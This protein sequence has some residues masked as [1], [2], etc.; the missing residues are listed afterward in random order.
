MTFYFVSEGGIKRSKAP[1]RT[2]LTTFERTALTMRM[3]NVGEGEAIVLSLG[4]EGVLFD[5]GGVV[6]KRN[7]PLGRALLAY[8][9]AEGIALNAIVA[10]HPHVDHL[11][12]LSTILAGDDPPSL[13]ADAVLY[14]NGEEMGI[15]LT[16]TLGERMDALSGSNRLEV[17]PVTASAAGRGLTDV[18]MIHFV[19][20][21]WKPRPAY[22]SIFTL[23]WYG[24][25]SFLFTGDAYTKYE[26]TLLA[27]PIGALIK[28]DVLKITHHGSDGGTGPEIADAV[29][30][31]IS[32]AS[33]SE[34]ASHRLEKE[35][36]DRL[37]S[38]GK[39]FDTYENG[40]DI[41]VR[42]DGR[43]RTSRGKPGV[44]YEVR[45]EKRGWYTGGTW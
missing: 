41:I 27:S 10:T 6:K 4:N 28:A 7:E 24:W 31:R 25:A 15:W 42:T 11:N 39:V 33:T 23:V 18:E 35:V 37:N 5:G 32:L 19:D 17:V 8:L 13:A 29:Q 43:Q 30:P 40:G 20:G 36:R 2:A 16:D 14:H 38:Y 1:S 34:H 3:F 21:R 12:A 44:L 22:K 9:D 26:N 45:I